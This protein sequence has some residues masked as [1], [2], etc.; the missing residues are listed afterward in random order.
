MSWI[1][2]QRHIL[3]RRWKRVRASMSNVDNGFTLTDV[4]WA[5]RM[6]LTHKL[7]RWMP[8]RVAWALVN[9]VPSEWVPRY[10][11]RKRG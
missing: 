1:S 7:A 11:I 3:M 2:L 9:L 5:R 4:M 10:G 8:R 6:H